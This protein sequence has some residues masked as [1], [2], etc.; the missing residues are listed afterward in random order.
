MPA[1]PFF[2]ARF[3]FPRVVF[4]GLLWLASCGW[5]SAAAAQ[6]PITCLATAADGQIVLAGS[7]AGLVCLTGRELQVHRRWSAPFANLHDLAFSPDGQTLAVAGGDPADMGHI[8]I[9]SWPELRLQQRLQGHD[10]SVLALQWLDNHRLASASLDRRIILWDVPQA[11][12]LHTLEGHSRGVTALAY[13]AQADVL[14]SGGWDH[15]LRV[16]HAGSGQ[17]QRSLNIHTQ[18]VHAVALRP[19][20]EGLP[21]IA[22]CSDDRTVRLWQPTI[23]RMVRFIRLPARPLGLCWMDQ[24]TWIAAGCDDGSVYAIDPQEVQIIQQFSGIQAGWVYAIAAAPDNL[25]LL[26]GGSG[27]EVKWID[28][29]VTPATP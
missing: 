29:P 8:E 17:L 12:P 28:P 2:F 13:L 22:S 5:T 26:V 4:L 6:P 20:T 25:G 7:Q 10:D 19:D 15:S 21:M 11:T 3:F 16:W 27:G 23:G 18:A 14:I 9:L 24:G 1:L